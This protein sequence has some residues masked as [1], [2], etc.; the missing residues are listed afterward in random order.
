MKKSRES[1]SRRDGDGKCYDKASSE[2]KKKVDPN[3][4]RRCGKTGHWTKECP[5]RRQGKKAKSHLVQADDDDEATLLMAMFYALHDVEAKE[6]GEG[7]AM[8]GPRKALKAVNL[9]EPI[10]Q[11]DERDSEVL[12]KDGVLRIRDQ[13]QR[14]LAKVEQP[15]CLAARH[16]E[17]LWLCHARFGHLSF[18]ALGQLEKMVR[19]L[20]HIKH[21]GELCDSYWARKQR[22]LSFPKASNHYM[23][24]QL[25]T[26]KDEAAAVIKKFKGVVRHHTALYSPQQNGVVEWWNQTVVDM[27]QSMMEAKGIPNKDSI[28]ADRVRL[29]SKRHHK[30]RGCFHDD[31]EVR[32]H[33]L[34]DIVGG[35]GSSGL[36]GRLFNDPELL[37]ISVE[38]PPT[39]ALAERDANWRRAMLEEM[40]AIEENETWKLVDP[41]L[42]C[43]SIGLKWVYKVKW[44]ERGAIVKHKAPLIARDFVQCEGI[45]FEEVFAPVVR[46]E[47][48]RLLLAL[49]AAKDWHI[50]HLD[51]KSA[52]LNEDI[53]SFKHEMTAHF[54]MNDLDVLSYYLGIEVRQGKEALTLGQSAYASKLLERSGM[55]E[56]KACVTPME[57]RLKLTKASTAAKV[58]AT[59]YRSIVGGLRYLVH[60]GRTLR[61]PWATSAASWR[62][63]ERIT[64]LR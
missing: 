21:E 18:D 10:G 37:L 19:G 33:K 5:N 8:E 51:I 50:H 42:G 57:E 49:A 39:F 34:D 38:E 14:L 17:E 45:D 20:P 16:T 63:P 7:T 44:D 47:S 25:L 46:I 58:D 11:L 28:D 41:P 3:A 9:D 54:R 48:I 26:S 23:W 56:C 31:E 43:R 22:R 32:A 15:M 13:E 36:V 6:K 1:S 29:T 2:K 59:L 61:S 24:L 27:A 55:S 53:D 30:V 4:Y 64:G 52:F 60:M 40:K 62:I 12:I 35:I